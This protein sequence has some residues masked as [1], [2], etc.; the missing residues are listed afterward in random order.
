MLS[1]CGFIDAGMCVMAKFICVIV[2]AQLGSQAI[3]GVLMLGD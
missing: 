2:E 3:V 1:D